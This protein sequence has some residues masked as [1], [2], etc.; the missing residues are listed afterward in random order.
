MIPHRTSFTAAFSAALLG[1]LTW[2]NPAQANCSDAIAAAQL[3]QP[4]LER[5]WQT[6]Q[7]QKAYPWGPI[8]PYGSLSADQI[9]LTPAFDRLDGAAK[10]R[11]VEL[12]R[13]GTKPDWLSL[14]TPAEQQQAVRDPGIGAIAPHTV[15]AHDG[16]LVSYAYD[17]CTRPILLTEFARYQQRWYGRD[18][19]LRTLR[20]PM[21][22]GKE[23]AVRRSFWQAL[24]HRRSEVRWIAWVPERG[25][26]EIT[27]ASNPGAERSLAPFWQVA[28]RSYRYV[29][30]NEDGTLLQRLDPEP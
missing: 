2:G 8:R 6:L 26:F 30:L 18:L 28:P 24:G 16:R 5:H 1:L 20:F 29:V 14:L 27:V 19:P 15:L 4:T 22:P 13:L 17:G 11:V 12:L 25:F 23:Q 21:D 3:V 7:R 10:R 9:T